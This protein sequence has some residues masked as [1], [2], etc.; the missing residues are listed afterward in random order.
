MS[1]LISK[2]KTV[3][4]RFVKFNGV[5]TLVGIIINFGVVAV[6]FNRLGELTFMFTMPC[7]AVLEFALIN[8][9]QKT[10]LKIF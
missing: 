6:L 5:G 9:L 2:I 7:G 3:A 8:L 4:F 1:S 10:K